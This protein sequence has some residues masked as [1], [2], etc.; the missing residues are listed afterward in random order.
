MQLKNDRQYFFERLTTRITN[1]LK[2]SARNAAKD[3]SI[4]FF[5]VKC[6]V[7]KGKKFPASRYRK[8]TSSSYC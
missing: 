8:T 5:S 6:P 3:L 1:F 2:N 4:D 7:D